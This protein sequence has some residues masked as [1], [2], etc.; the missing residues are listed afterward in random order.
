M[1]GYIMKK[2]THVRLDSRNRIS[3]TKVSKH[4]P[5]SFSA[6][7]EKGRIILE[8]IVEVPVNEAWLFE[9]ENDAILKKVKEGLKQKGKI[10]RGS[11]SK[12]LK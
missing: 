2:K 12:Y 3:L 6:Y 11:F 1:K 9:P 4:L 7:V 5:S 10:K 8:P